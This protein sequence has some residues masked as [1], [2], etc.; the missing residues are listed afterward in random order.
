MSL[1][2]MTVVVVTAFSG[3]LR[4]LVLWFWLVDRGIGLGGFDAN[5]ASTFAGNAIPI[6]Y[7]I[8]ETF[9]NSDSYDESATFV[10][11]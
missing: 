11:L 10:Y 9:T 1:F 6:G 5:P 7:V 4:L 8:T 2:P 3:V